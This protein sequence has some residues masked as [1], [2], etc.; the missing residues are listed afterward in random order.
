MLVGTA[1]SSLL[2]FGAE[3][4]TQGTTASTNRTSTASLVGVV[5]VPALPQSDRER[6]TLDLW[7]D[8]LCLKESKCNPTE[9]HLDVN[10]RYSYGCFQFQMGTW[11][12]YA[13]RFGTTEGNIYDCAL[14]RK[15]ARYI[16][17]IEHGWRH[18]KLTVLT[19]IGYPPI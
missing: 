2:A 1:V 9:K 7:L 4:P 11:L 6:D 8:Q 16:I 19:K 5:P 15:V 10:N 17:T 13:K 3:A 18:W 12:A 14:Q